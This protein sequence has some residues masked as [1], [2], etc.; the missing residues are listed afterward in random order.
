MVRPVTRDALG[1]VIQQEDASSITDTISDAFSLLGRSFDDLENEFNRRWAEARAD[2]GY[3]QIGGYRPPLIVQNFIQHAGSVTTAGTVFRL[4]STNRWVTVDL[5]QA[6]SLTYTYD[7]IE[8]DIVFWLDHLKSITKAYHESRTQASPANA[9]N[10]ASR[11]ASASVVPAPG[12][13]RMLLGRAKGPEGG[14]G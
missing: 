5:P 8:Q 13:R 14:E 2:G 6:D 9:V 10:Q 3:V 1:R 11:S 7:L 12:A 4:N